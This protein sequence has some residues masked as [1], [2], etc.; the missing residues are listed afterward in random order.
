MRR[1]PPF[2]VILLFLVSCAPA[3][4]VAP[5]ATVVPP[6]AI[7]VPTSEPTS[8]LL[9]TLTPEPTATLTDTPYPVPE[10]AVKA[11]DGSTVFV[12]EGKLWQLDA[13]GQPVEKD[14]LDVTFA[15]VIDSGSIVKQL[16]PEYYTDDQKLLKDML[17]PK[18]GEITERYRSRVDDFTT[19]SLATNVEGLNGMHSILTAGYVLD[20]TE[21][22]LRGYPSLG[23]EKEIIL[24]IAFA[25]AEQPVPVVMGVIDSKGQYSPLIRGYASASVGSSL[26]EGTPKYKVEKSTREISEN[27]Q[28]FQNECVGITLIGYVDPDKADQFTGMKSPFP[29]YADLAHDA[30]VNHAAN[31]AWRVR[32]ENKA[33][34]KINK[35]SGDFLGDVIE[36]AKNCPEELGPGFI[37]DQPFVVRYETK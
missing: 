35:T 5:S 9:P 26:T 36:S 15:N 30:A 22:D 21:V 33:D 11:A 3:A 4:S 17:L 14:I 16:H 18:G 32:Q 25:D 31:L 13:Q 23:L 28:Y 37:P 12:K 2:F 34:G 29:K 19:L 7:S 8:R 6:T 1:F 27:I 24:N 20:I 10:G